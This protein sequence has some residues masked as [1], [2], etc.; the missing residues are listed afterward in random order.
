MG[1]LAA[2]LIR[3][4]I[5]TGYRPVFNIRQQSFIALSRGAEGMG[6]GLYAAETREASLKYGPYRVIYPVGIHLK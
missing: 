4:S 6:N 5:T 2:S 1:N 3:F